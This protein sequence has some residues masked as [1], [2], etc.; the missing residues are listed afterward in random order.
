MRF[1]FDTEFFENGK[2]IDLIS[3]GVVAE[4]NSTFYAEVEEFVFEDEKHEWLSRNV[5]P[6]LTRQ[7]M[8]YHIIGKE[9]QQFVLLKTDKPEFWA[10]YADYD[11]IALCQLYG[12]MLDLP[13]QFPKLCLDLKQ[14]LLRLNIKSIPIA[15]HMEHNALADAIWTKEVHQWIERRMK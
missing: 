6:F 11:W 1:W 3:I 13:S 7:T 4:D 15:N 2:T 10:Y 8:P 12:T 14:E 5:K 9:L